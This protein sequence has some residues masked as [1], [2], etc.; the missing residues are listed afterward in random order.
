MDS[1]G[2]SKE[3]QTTEK[4][5]WLQMLKQA[6]E[7]FLLASI[8]VIS[9]LA[10]ISLAIVAPFVLMISAISGIFSGGNETRRW[11]PVNA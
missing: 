8:I 6:E 10:V 7:A 4:G 5:F 11:R 9:S 2:N 1:S 3:I